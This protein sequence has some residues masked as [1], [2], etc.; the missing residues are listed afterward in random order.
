MTAKPQF[1]WMA[2]AILTFAALS[3]AAAFVTRNRSRCPAT[4]IHQRITGRRLNSRAK[5]GA[6]PSPIAS[7]QVTSVAQPL[8]PYTP[9][10][11]NSFRVH[12][13]SEMVP[14]FHDRLVA[15]LSACRTGVVDCSSIWLYIPMQHSDLIVKGQLE[16]HGFAFHHCMPHSTVLVQWL[17]TDRPSPIPPYA[18]H[19]VGV[20]SLVV[21]DDGKRILCVRELRTITYPGN[22]RR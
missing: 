3:K 8:L 21:D 13:A 10:S 2:T 17:R 5:D 19:N 4:C 9:G 7:T 22:F 6:S 11:H 18:T 14:N 15:T 12:V 20:G 1:V 16:R